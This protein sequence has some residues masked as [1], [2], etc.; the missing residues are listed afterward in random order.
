M[1]FGVGMYLD[2]ISV[3]FNGLGRH[4]WRC[5]FWPILRKYSDIVIA[6]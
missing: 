3:V 6:M 5:D 2:H 4:I 1:K